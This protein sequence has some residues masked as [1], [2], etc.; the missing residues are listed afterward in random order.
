MIYPSLDPTTRAATSETDSWTKE[1]PEPTATTTRTNKTA[2]RNP[3]RK[4]KAA[5]P[6]E[7]AR[8]K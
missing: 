1:K 8:R 4:R 3:W 2:A 5:L 6:P 7:T